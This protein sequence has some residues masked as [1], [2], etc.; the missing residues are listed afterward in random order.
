MYIV[1]SKPKRNSVYSG[2]DHIVFPYEKLPKPYEPGE[3]L[4]NLE[5]SWNC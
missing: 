5:L 1:T 2:L 3:L 4:T